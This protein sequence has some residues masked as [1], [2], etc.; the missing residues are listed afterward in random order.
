MA[1]V[2]KEF[3]IPYC[4]ASDKA[5]QS[6]I[7]SLEKGQQQESGFFLSSLAVA[8]TSPFCIWNDQTFN[9]IQ[10]ILVQK[11]KCTADLQST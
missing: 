9:N 4:S 5:P 8:E 7:C 10:V 3:A 2:Y 1:V 11:D 6:V